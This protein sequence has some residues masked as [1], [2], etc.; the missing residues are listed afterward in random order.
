MDNR[1]KVKVTPQIPVAQIFTRQ[2]P[3][4]PQFEDHGKEEKGTKR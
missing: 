4:T 3:Y 2:Q 1:S